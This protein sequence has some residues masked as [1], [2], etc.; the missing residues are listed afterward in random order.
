[1]ADWQITDGTF[2]NY[3]FHTAKRPGRDVKSGVQSHG[4]QEER[5]LQISERA[6]VDVDDVEDFG[7]KSRIFTSK[8]IFYGENYHPELKKFKKIL[9]EGTSGVLI[10]PDEPDAVY[11]KYHKSS[12]DTSVDFGDATV[13]DVTWIED[14]KTQ[15]QATDGTTGD[16]AQAALASGNTAQ[17]IPTIQEQAAKANR[18]ADAAL[19]ALNNNPL[20][21][22]LNAAQT[23]VT[24]ARVTINSIANLPRNQRQAILSSA[25]RI[26]SDVNGLKSAL[27]GLLAYTDILNISETQSSPTRYNSGVGAVDYQA[28]NT[29]STAVVSGNQQLVVKQTAST[30]IQSFDE[31]AQLLSDFSASI[32]QTSKELETS[33]SGSVQDFSLGAI[34]LIN[35]VK[36]LISIIQSKP[37]SKVFTITRTTLLEVC[38]NNG[39]NVSDVDRVYGLNR[40]LSDILNIPAGTAINLP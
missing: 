26:T 9:N 34:Q 22:A 37:T 36:D 7:R 4:E 5:R 2:K 21:K 35:A 14:R 27:N 38:F 10:L 18:R 39:L 6:R 13:L 33:T 30:Q 8:I 17:A 31:A 1:M 20:I 24:N 29:V 12:R 11:A 32:D 23:A 19:S 16:I 3:K 28:V 25:T 40:N 15:I